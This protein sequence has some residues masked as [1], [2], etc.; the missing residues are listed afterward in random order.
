MQRY[1][2]RTA[3]AVRFVTVM[4]EAVRYLSFL[5]QSLV[6]NIT[7]DIVTLQEELARSVILTLQSER[8]RNRSLLLAQVK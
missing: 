8:W 2:H 4:R 6:S 1:K 3:N 5:L 7:S